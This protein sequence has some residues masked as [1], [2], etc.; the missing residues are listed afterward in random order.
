MHGPS[1]KHAH[2]SI[3]ASARP[4]GRHLV[5]QPIHPERLN[6][7]KSEQDK[8]KGKKKK[9]KKRKKIRSR[10]KSNKKCHAAKPMA[11]HEPNR[12]R[13]TFPRMISTRSLK[14]YLLPVGASF[15]AHPPQQLTRTRTHNHKI[16]TYIYIHTHTSHRNIA[17]VRELSISSTSS[18]RV[19]AMCVYRQRWEGLGKLGGHRTRPRQHH[20]S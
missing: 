10:S 5:G 6:K 7:R 12:C 1:R 2:A 14:K 16:H 13:R 4:L 17:V 20:A 18:H 3:Q 8:K 11:G 9:K 15:S 19:R